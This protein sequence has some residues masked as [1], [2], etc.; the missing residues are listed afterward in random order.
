[1]LSRSEQNPQLVPEFPERFRQKFSQCQ[2]RLVL[3]QLQNIDANADARIRIAQ[4][5][6]DELSGIPGLR[7][8]PRL[9][10]RAHT[11]MAFPV[12]VED[13][14][15]IIRHLLLS[16]RDVA[17]Q[18]IRNCADLSV[19]SEYKSNC[20]NAAATAESVVLLPTYPSYGH[21]EAIKTACA[22]R[23]FFEG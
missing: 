10:D 9:N 21:K 3:Q 2:A 15:A 11:Y 13:R 23:K 12:Q 14:D 8:P 6:F 17:G 18:H 16:G 20:P 4:I 5:Y 7:L 22:V 19:F 1:M